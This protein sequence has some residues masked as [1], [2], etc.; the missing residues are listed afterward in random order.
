MTGRR[1][2]FS[3]VLRPGPND[4][5]PSGKCA[6]RAATLEGRHIQLFIVS[7]DRLQKAVADQACERQRQVC[8]APRCKRQPHILV[9][10]QDAAPLVVLFGDLPAA[11][12]IDGRCEQGAGHE[13][14]KIRRLH[15]VRTGQCGGVS[16]FCRRLV[17]QI[18]DRFGKRELQNDL[19]FVVGHFEDCVEHRRLTAFGFQQL[20][21]RG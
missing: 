13:I 5:S 3:G 12:L 6:R 18:E 11:A 19:P 15:T 14:D 20:P 21:D 1:W 8:V 2:R 17:R 9:T 4:Q 10:H 16:M 7:G